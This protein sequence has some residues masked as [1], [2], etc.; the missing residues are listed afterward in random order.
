[1]SSRLTARSSYRVI[2]LNLVLLLFEFL[3]YNNVNRYNAKALKANTIRTSTVLKYHACLCYISNQ[4]TKF[5]TRFN[6]QLIVDM[7]Q[8]I[9]A[10]TAFWL[11]CKECCSYGH[12]R[13]KVSVYN[14]SAFPAAFPACYYCPE[15]LC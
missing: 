9:G 5:L 8:L 15:E 7:P 6:K 10:A 4:G 13:S 1:H 11:V 3:S 14:A 2:Y 12:Q